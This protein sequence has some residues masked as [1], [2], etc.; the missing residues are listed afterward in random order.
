MAM[1]RRRGK[2]EDYL[3][4]GAPYP[5]LKLLVVNY[6]TKDSQVPTFDG[7]S[8]LSLRENTICMFYNKEAET[9]EHLFQKCNYLADV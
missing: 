2:L 9:V 5:K 3:G 6:F 1:S 8:R 7:L 4:A